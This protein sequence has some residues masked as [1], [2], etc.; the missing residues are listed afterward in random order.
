MKSPDH[1]RV[2]SKWTAAAAQTSQDP[3][4]PQAQAPQALKLDTLQAFS[5]S[6][7]KIANLTWQ[8]FDVG[9]QL[10]IAHKL[11]DTVAHPN[12]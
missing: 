6:N 12:L 7:A 2:F 5:D 1:P 11:V 8:D 4:A 3:Q 10:L 9:A